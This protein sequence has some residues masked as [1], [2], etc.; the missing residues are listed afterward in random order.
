MATRNPFLMRLRRQSPALL[1]ALAAGWCGLTARPAAA[2]SPRE[3]PASRRAAPPNAALAA[4]RR[5]VLAARP[6][7]LLYSSAGEGRSLE[8]LRAHAAQITLF[9]PQAY[10]IAS[11]GVVTGALSPQV[12]AFCRQARVPVMPLLFNKEFERSTVSALLHSA[13]AQRRAVSYMAYLAGRENFLG[14][15]I[16]LENIAPEDSARFTRFVARAAAR[17]H[18]DGRLLSVAVVPR[19]DPVKAGNGPQGIWSAAFDYRALGKAADFLTLMTYD[20]SGRSGPAGPIAGYEWVERALDYAVRRVPPSKL[21]MGIPLYGREW[22]EDA[23]HT[24]A[25]SLT[26]ADV[27]ALLARQGIQPRWNERWQS[28]WF[29]YHDGGVRRT[30]WYE[31]ARSWAAKLAL[32]RRYRLRGFAAWQL[33]M[34]GP[35][36]WTLLA[37]HS[38]AP[39][40]RAGK[41]RPAP[42]VARSDAAAGKDGNR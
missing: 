25:R 22:T 35:D 9:A 42:P 11:D 33:G 6:L 19:F 13:P 16:D 40:H 41:R 7:A 36:F 34:A 31:N 21:L 27:R 2:P 8:A 1:L 5:K 39:A 20:H 28:P 10:W 3:R 26:Q 30:V 23:A 38:A 37:A 29:E 32:M 14:F 4:A 18:R 15:Q 17:L 24:P 12:L